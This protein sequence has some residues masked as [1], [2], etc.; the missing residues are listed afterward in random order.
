MSNGRR[1]SWAFPL[2]VIVMCFLAVA[3]RA[4]STTEF[5]SAQSPGDDEQQLEDL[6]A[7]VESL[8]CEGRYAEAIPVAEEALEIRVRLSGEG[9]FQV[10][11][12]ARQIELFKH[13]SALPVEA[14]T[15]L[16]EA[17]RAD[18]E[19]D[20]CIEQRDLARGL[21]LARNQLAVRRQYLGEEHLQVS[22]A[23]N[24]LGVLHMRS[25][26]LDRAVSYFAKAFTIDQAELEPDD[27]SLALTMNNLGGTLYLQH[28]YAA[29]E[30][31]LEDALDILCRQYD[32]DHP[33]AAVGGILSFLGTISRST[34]ETAKAESY[35]RRALRAYL[36]RFPSD[37]PV[38]L[39]ISNNLGVLLLD[40]RKFSEAEPYL[41]D[42]WN[43]LRALHGD[44]HHDVAK[45]LGNWAG[46]LHHQGNYVEAEPMYRDALS[47]LRRRLGD[48]HP[49][50]ANTQTNLA[51]LLRA[52]GEIAAAE[53]LCQAALATRRDHCQ[54]DPTAVSVSLFLEAILQ[55]DRY[56]FA[57]A[58]SMIQ[59]ALKIAGEHRGEDH[60]EVARYIDFLAWQLHERGDYEHAEQLARKA[61]EIRVRSFGEGHLDVGYSLTSLGF[62]LCERGED[63][64]QEMLREGLAIVRRHIGD[65]HPMVGQGLNL[66][67]RLLLQQGKYDEAAAHFS[68]A[69]ER[70]LR[71]LGEN[72]PD[73][74]DS[75][76]KLGTV[77]Y[78]QGKLTEATQLLADAAANFEVARL[79]VARTGFV[80]VHFDARQSPQSLLAACLARQ[81]KP[82]EAWQQLENSFARGLLDAVS[83]R[84][85]RPLDESERYREANLLRQL[86]ALEER[87]PSLSAKGPASE[88]NSPLDE[89]QGQ[90]ASLELALIEFEEEMRLEYGVTRG[91]V[92]PLEEIQTHLSPR[93]ALVAW[94]DIDADRDGTDCEGDHWACVVRHV[95][96]PNWIRLKGTGEGGA[97]TEE[98]RQ[99]PERVRDTLSLNPFHR[100][101][102]TEKGGS[103]QSLLRRLYALRLQP[104]ESHLSGREDLEPV[105]QLIMLPVGRMGNIPIEAL[106]DRYSVIY[107]PSATMYAWLAERGEELDVQGGDPVGPLL[108]LGDPLF[109]PRGREGRGGDALADGSGPGRQTPKQPAGAQ[110]TT[111]SRLPATRVEVEAIA[112][113]LERAR[114][115]SGEPLDDSDDLRVLLGEAA[116]EENIE[117]LAASDR[118]TRYRYLH[119]A[120]HGELDDRR[121]MGSSLIL[122]QHERLEPPESVGAGVE[123]CDGRITPDQIIR[124]WKLDADLVT[125]SA[126]ST[127]LGKR[128]GG[129]GSM[130]FAQAL[131]VVGARNLVLSLW[132]VDDR[133]TCLLMT[134]FYENLLG[135]FEEPRSMAGLVYEPSVGMPKAVALREAKE[136]LRNLSRRDALVAERGLGLV[137]GGDNPE[138]APALSPEPRDR[139]H[140][141]SDPYFWAAF[142][143]I[144]GSG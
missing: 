33:H 108:A 96:L 105:E 17:D 80:R 2:T 79:Q 107:A 128:V 95:G 65:D 57:A 73:T 126:C 91:V 59:E 85:L 41:E 123:Y 86:N 143:L 43:G 114:T 127:G 20:R 102:P 144:G 4:G 3:V 111:N 60:P 24:T 22:E 141:Y 30:P 82:L 142:V 125:L 27:P 23:F 81:G 83:A 31:Y 115:R 109:S 88:G 75:M 61:L 121:V 39:S 90:R 18:R 74:V 120:T 131:L 44:D 9:H 34:G 16:G 25:K 93:A 101:T 49:T 29:A 1:R 68:D 55:N 100:P 132:K 19:I 122:S 63:G 106:T 119:L 129:E 13:I 51:F 140:W 97:W 8:R 42:S 66:W 7:R 48:H 78:Q 58:E 136:W 36:V 72:H 21:E 139:D 52:R 84:H 38:V 62:M 47:V 137:R 98:D 76:T 138:S 135:V 50:V 12:V 53:R 35:Y 5:C 110:E 89:L 46:A 124:N 67:G 133:A 37:H 64:A 10:A 32:D 45:C 77:L 112:A 117:E 40:Q 99:L 104:V 6:S 14:R 134:R 28:D 56:D 130:G 71:L 54:Q 69:L 15:K 26:D 94:L 116:C 113:L 70:Q 87:I 92:L 103:L 11:E 118:L